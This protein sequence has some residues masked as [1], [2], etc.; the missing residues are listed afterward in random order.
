MWLHCVA[1]LGHFSEQLDVTCHASLPLLK[2]MS[3]YC[4]PA[5]VTLRGHRSGCA[6]LA[7]FAIAK[8]EVD[9]IVF[10]T[11]FAALGTLRGAPQGSPHPPT[12]NCSTE[13]DESKT[14]LFTQGSSTIPLPQRLA[15]L[16]TPLKEFGLAIECLTFMQLL[17]AMCDVGGKPTPWEFVIKL[18]HL[19][20]TDISAQALAVHA[21]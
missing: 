7:Q 11:Y 1:V 15:W 18:C 14:R 19:M 13:R 21:L 12:P 8:P 10:L 3:R 20:L 2:A 9:V 16:Q 5:Q 4:M 6:I 17:S